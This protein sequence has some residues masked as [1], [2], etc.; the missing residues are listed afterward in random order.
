MVL[1]PYN[2]SK[3]HM[4]VGVQGGTQVMLAPGL[5]VTIILALEP[6]YCCV[7][8]ATIKNNL[9]DLHI[10]CGQSSTSYNKYALYEGVARCAV[11]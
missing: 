1:G 7:I 5:Q 4:V 9:N 10:S 6:R 2:L 8:D 11:G 3:N